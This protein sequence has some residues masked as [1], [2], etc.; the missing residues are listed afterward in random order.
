MRLLP[1]LE[2]KSIDYTYR[3]GAGSNVSYVRERCLRPLRPGTTRPKVPFFGELPYDYIMWIDSD[4]AFEPQHFWK[5]V[6]ND[7]D[8]VAGAYKSDQETYSSE[9]Y[10]RPPVNDLIE[11]VWAGMGFML[12]K[13]GVFEKIEPP[14]FQTRTID[15]DTKK[16]QFVT[17]D[18]YFCQRAREAGFK[19]WINPEVAVG[20]MKEHLLI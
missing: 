8:I 12:I 14:W 6:E 18:I 1:S 2:T 10:Q 16:D 13:K 7:V 5:L 19:I 4:I 20:H 15:I 3:R 9:V 11:A 17:E